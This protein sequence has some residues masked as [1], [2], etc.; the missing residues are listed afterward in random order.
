MAETLLQVYADVARPLGLDPSISSFSETD[1]SADIV[2]YIYEGYRSL[3]R[4]LRVENEYFQKEG[5]I[6]TADGT[7]TYALA[8]D[9]EP[10]GL[11]QFDV[12]INDDTN[13]DTFLNAATRSGVRAM[14]AKWDVTE[15]K[16]SYYYFSDKDTMAF[17]PIPDAVYNIKYTYQQNISEDTATTAVFLIPDDWLEYVKKYAQFQWESAKGM[18]SPDMTYSLMES[19]YDSIRVAEWRTNPTRLSASRRV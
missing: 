15:G 3:R 1:G 14:D 7:R 16:P 13:G 12:Y 8:S 2:Q 9:A 6:T 19:I 10:F 11:Y 18:G 4:R 5:T 17:Y